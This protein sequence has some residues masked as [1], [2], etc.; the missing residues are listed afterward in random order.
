MNS[1]H[2]N[3]SMDSFTRGSQL[4]M[5][6]MRMVGQGAKIACITSI[7]FVL[8]WTLFKS[9]RMLTLPDVY[10]W[11]CERWAVM[12]FDIGMT[13]YEKN[14]LTIAIYDFSDGVFKIF[15]PMEYRQMVWS[16]MVGKRLMLYWH[17]LSTSALI[18]FINIF[19]AGMIFTYVFFVI[20]G[21]KIIGKKKIRGRNIITPKKL[22]AQLKKSGMASSITIG[23]LPLVKDSERQH[24][25]ITGTTGTG[26]TNLLHDI[27][28]QIRASGNKA[29]IVDLTGSFVGPYF[30]EKRDFLLN[31]F[32]SRSVSWLP[33]VDCHELYDYDSLAAAIIGEA[34]HHDTFWD[35][36]AK[37]ILAEALYKFKEKQSISEV[38]K[39]LNTSSLS[40]YSEFFK[41]T[42]VASLT[43]KAAD[44]TATSIRA[45]MSNK[46]RALSYLK[47]TRTPFSIKDYVMNAANAS[48]NSLKYANN[49]LYAKGH[50][51]NLLDTSYSIYLYRTEHKKIYAFVVHSVQ[52]YET[53][54]ITSIEDHAKYTDSLTW[55]EAISNKKEKY[56]S[57]TFPS[58]LVE[59]II[60]NC[61]HTCTPWLFITAMPSQR[62]ALGPLLSAWIE[63]A[64]TGLMQRD[65]LSQN[66]NIWIVMDELAGLGKIPSLKTGLAEARKYGGC[67][68]AAAQNIHQLTDIYGGDGAYNLLDQFN[69]RFIFRVGDQKTAQMAAQMLGE[70][71]I[72]ETKESLS[73]GANTMRDGVNIST[74]E[75]NRALI[76]PT[77]IMT[78]PNLTCYVK[79]SGNWPITK[80]A[81][82]YNAPNVINQ[83]FSAKTV[84]YSHSIMCKT[85]SPDFKGKDIGIYLYRD[86]LQNTNIYALIIHGRVIRETLHLSEIDE[87]KQYIIDLKWPN[88]ADIKK[89]E[90]IDVIL[91]AKLEKLVIKNCTFS[92][93]VTA[94]E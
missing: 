33:W 46:V 23:K 36:S 7:F 38:L 63:V 24:I 75:R 88:D 79:L 21:R 76:L 30:E 73:Y 41:D 12:K 70:Q 15:G 3:H 50:P 94:H 91:H 45:T 60:F 53:L 34:S 35:D 78:L 42:K 31:P 51:E 37:K 58:G 18:E 27:I 62:K 85:G 43:D 1:K 83:L 48:E 72:Q 26:K 20:Q 68:L 86:N 29:I 16:S 90:Y 64:I 13:F 11:I 61:E 54:D 59:L 69:T 10:Y 65:P 2:K 84:P 47:E 87:C 74:T 71:E 93:D 67:V 19:S 82:Q 14:E 44:R 81:M 5:H 17:W 8:V 55:P 56:V 39:V 4:F 49:M 6:A 66:N 52:Q 28:P 77:E 9:S 89:S 40:D 80:L 32:D 25:L 57:T 92:Q 22:T